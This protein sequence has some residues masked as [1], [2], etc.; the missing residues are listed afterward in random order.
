MK[1]RYKKRRKSLDFDS[2]LAGLISPAELARLAEQ[3]RSKRGRPPRI[4]FSEIFRTLL[5][6][7]CQT[8]G[9]LS[10]HHEFLHGERCSDAGIAHRRQRAPWEVFT[11]ILDVVLKPRATKRGQKTAFYK[12][13]RLVGLDGTRF[14]VGNLPAILQQCSKAVSRRLKAAFAKINVSILLEIGLHNP[15][16]AAIAHEQESEWEL[17]TRLLSKL[18]RNSLLLADRLYGCGAFLDCVVQI[19]TKTASE[20]LIRAR[21][22]VGKGAKHRKSLPDGSRLISLPVAHPTIQHRVTHY[23][24]VREIQASLQRPGKQAVRL[25]FFTSLLDERRYPA[26]E[27]VALYAQRWGH[28]VYHRQLK[29]DLRRS[30]LLNSHT[31]ETA[32]QEIAALLIASALIAQQRKTVQ[33]LNPEIKVTD[34]SF[35]RVHDMTRAHW[36]FC[37]ASEDIISST[38][39]RQI[40]LRLFKALLPQVIP[41]KRFRSYPRAVRQPI[42]GWPRKLRNSYSQ[43]APC[44]NI[45]TRY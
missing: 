20:Y 39:E 17:S 43:T 28:E 2:V 29:H 19:C 11:S 45:L 16:A 21:K 25:R 9:V 32:C 23:L 42:K 14:S 41:K 33:E 26:E 18:P 37:I 7:A 34:I 24:R 40:T 12:G 10:Q 31:V 1:R 30:E 5:F 35:R 44:I 38:Q 6:G 13:L 3:R 4:P 22:N 27:L 8:A 15:V 36:N